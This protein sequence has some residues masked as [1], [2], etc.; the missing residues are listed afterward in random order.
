MTREK[1]SFK[2][3]R[4]REKYKTTFRN[5]CRVGGRKSML[6]VEKSL[7]NPSLPRTHQPADEGV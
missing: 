1:D 3:G 5:M 6:V 7:F 2:Q 4:R